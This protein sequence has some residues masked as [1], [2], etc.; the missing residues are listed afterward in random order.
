M[1]RSLWTWLVRKPG[2]VETIRGAELVRASDQ[3]FT[4]ALL[5]HD[6]PDGDG[7]RVVAAEGP[8]RAGNS[9]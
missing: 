6:G 8:D 1:T 4:S 9:R 3:R 5:L 7:G 2:R